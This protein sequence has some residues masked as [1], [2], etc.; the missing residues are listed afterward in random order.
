M[1]D[2]SELNRLVT[3]ALISEPIYVKW[4][5]ASGQVYKFELN[6]I[7]SAYRPFAGIYIFCHFGPRNSLVADYIDRADDFSEAL[8]G[9][10]TEHPGWESIREAGSTHVCT[11]RIEGKATRRLFVDSDLRRVLVPRKTEDEIAA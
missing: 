3:R 5:G 7:G 1:T 4:T 10:I 6:P 11:L 8:D 9:D 2:P